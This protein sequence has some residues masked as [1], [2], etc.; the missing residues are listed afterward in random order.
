MALRPSWSIMFWWSCS[1]VGVTGGG[2]EGCCA[3]RLA[4]AQKRLS[5][6]TKRKGFEKGTQAPEG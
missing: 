4:P 1:A 6:R 3:A 2:D 5:E